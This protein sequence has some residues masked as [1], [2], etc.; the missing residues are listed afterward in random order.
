MLESCGWRL[1]QSTVAVEEDKCSYE[2]ALTNSENFIVLIVHPSSGYTGA[3]AVSGLPFSECKNVGFPGDVPKIIAL[4]AILVRKTKIGEFPPFFHAQCPRIFCK[5][6]GK[7]LLDGFY[8]EIA[9]PWLD[10]L[11]PE[12]EW[13]P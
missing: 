9:K 1:R 3:N 8:P 2:Q 5:D 11:Q 10:T 7:L 6:L 12:S 13:Y 4:T